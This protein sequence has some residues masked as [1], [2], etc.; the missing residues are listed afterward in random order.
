MDMDDL[1]R[2]DDGHD[3]LHDELV[4]SAALVGSVVVFLLVM[5]FLGR[6]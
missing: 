5:T 2:D 6:L 3:E 4:W 1:G